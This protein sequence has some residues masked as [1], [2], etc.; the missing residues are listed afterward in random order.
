M[1]PYR[2]TTGEVDMAG[3]RPAAKRST[4][5][6]AGGALF[7]VLTGVA[8]LLMSTGGLATKREVAG[9]RGSAVSRAGYSFRICS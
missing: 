4:R 7:A 8:T 1:S 9:L 6:A 3:L 5:L 2:T